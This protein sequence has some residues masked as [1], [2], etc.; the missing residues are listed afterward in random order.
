MTYQDHTLN[1]WLK[2]LPHSGQAL[3]LNEQGV[4]LARVAKNMRTQFIADETDE[5]C[6]IR[7][8]LLSTEKAPISLL[9]H[10]LSI[11]FLKHKTRGA[12]LGLDEERQSLVLSYRMQTQGRDAK[13][14]TNTLNNLLK[15]ATEI[16]QELEQ[17][18]DTV[19]LSPIPAAANML[20]A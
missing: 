12:S 11:N 19:Q 9:N 3:S 13:Q 18:S 17:V 14:F 20:M 8:Y 1:Y 2:E 7:L 10:A 4:C 16:K 5:C 15:A 6:W